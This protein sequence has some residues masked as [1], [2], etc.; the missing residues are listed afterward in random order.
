MELPP[1]SRK[2]YMRLHKDRTF[3]YNK[4]KSPEQIRKIFQDIGSIY[5]KFS[6][7]GCSKNFLAVSSDID[8]EIEKAQSHA[9]FSGYLNNN[10]ES[11]NNSPVKK[12][13]FFPA[14]NKSQEKSLIKIHTKLSPFT[15]E[16]IS[17]NNNLRNKL[18]L[19]VPIRLKKIN[20]IILQCKDMR[21]DISVDNTEAQEIIGKSKSSYQ[22]LS[23]KLGSKADI[24][25]ESR[26]NQHFNKNEYSD[27][28]FIKVSK[29]FRSGKRI[30]K[31]NHL[32]F[33]K[34]IDKVVSSFK[35]SK[36]SIY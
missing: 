22:K 11:I 34:G 23:K 32:S 21:E 14:L 2:L 6:P 24:N 5:N 29:N 28:D 4:K 33:I 25:I 3:N 36:D 9:S 17:K 12:L 8:R 15:D 7:T 20:Q 27:E 18:K 16:N 19:G 30:W 26:C 10:K 13:I 31:L 35:T 1:K